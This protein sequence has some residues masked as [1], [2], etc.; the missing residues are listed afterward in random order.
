MALLSA[1]Q[2]TAVPVLHPLRVALLSTGDELQEGAAPLGPGRII[3]SNRPMLR[4]LLHGLGCSVADLGILPDDPEPL[5][6][7]LIAAAAAHDLI[8]T[9]GGASVGDADH[10]N[11]LI[12]RRGFMEFWRLNMRPGKPVGLGDIDDCPILALPGNPMAAA[13][14]FTL[15]GQRLIGRLAGDPVLRPDALSMPLAHAATKGAGRLEILAG[16]RAILPDGQSGVAAL[17]VQGS[18]SLVALS[19]AEGLI[20]LPIAADKVAAGALVA[21]VPFGR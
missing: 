9:S 6:A 2:V 17:K 20:V 15:I 5:L 13:V 14:A 16:R 4:A 7:T 11:R 12:A 3:D 21:F 10:L 8:I 1:M 18:A 19:Q